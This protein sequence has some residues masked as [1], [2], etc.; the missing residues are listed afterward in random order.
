MPKVLTVD[1]RAQAVSAA[2]NSIFSRDLV[3]AVYDRIERGEQV[4][5]FLNRR[6]YATHMSCPHCGYVANCPECSID[7]TYHRAKDYLSCH[8]CGSVI[9]APQHCPSCNAPDIKYSGVGTE[10]IESIAAKLF[11]LAR[12]RRMDSDTM[13][14]K[15]SY[16]NC[17]TCFS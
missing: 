5:I 12:V 10:K 7:Y 15:K 13:T 16:E 11:P 9:R 6:G 1:M 4:I 2:G 14:H 17:S 3:A 8:I